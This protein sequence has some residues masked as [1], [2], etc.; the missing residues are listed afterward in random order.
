MDSKVTKGLQ[1]TN[2]KCPRGSNE[3]A[4]GIALTV[5]RNHGQQNGRKSHADH[6]L[7]RGQR[8]TNRSSRLKIRERHSHED[9]GKGRKDDSEDCWTQ[10]GADRDGQSGHISSMPVLAGN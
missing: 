2:D 3:H 10:D 4:N 9:Q 5:D 8:N 1:E 7:D 6:A